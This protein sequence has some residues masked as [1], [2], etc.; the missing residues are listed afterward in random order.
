MFTRNASPSTPHPEI[1]VAVEIWV[2]YPPTE[3]AYESVV[4][5][6]V[7]SEHFPTDVHLFTALFRSLIVTQN[8]ENFHRG[9]SC[10]FLTHP[11]YFY[12]F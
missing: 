3:L 2:P 5:V 1:N 7:R 8:W 9:E 10:F 12:L 6:I 11:F 4:Q